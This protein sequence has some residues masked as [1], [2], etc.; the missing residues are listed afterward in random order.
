LLC[1]TGAS[2]NK[3]NFLEICATAHT[4]T[5]TKENI[6]QAFVKT[7]VWPFCHDVVTDAMITPSKGPGFHG[8]GSIKGN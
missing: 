5:L 4:C 6:L 7:G 8:C 3:T 2:L 1:N